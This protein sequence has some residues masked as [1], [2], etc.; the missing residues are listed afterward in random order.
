M[1]RLS[2]VATS[3]VYFTYANPVPSEQDCGQIRAR[4]GPQTIFEVQPEIITVPSTA[5][6][7]AA[8]GEPTTVDSEPIYFL[9]PGSIPSAWDPSANTTSPV[10]G[11][12]TTTASSDA[13]SPTDSDDPGLA[14]NGTDNFPMDASRN[15][16]K[17][18]KVMAYYPDW[19][20]ASFPPEKIDFS[21]FDWIDFAFAVPDSNYGLG[22]DGSDSAPDL[23]K[24]LVS[25]AHAKGKMVKLS[26]GG[27]TGSKCVI[28]DSSSM[29]YN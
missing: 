17:G 25:L 16:L 18:P 2:L 24:R 6:V 27:W 12:A 15:P 5:T 7:T 23:L 20:A 26:I 10:S 19:V 8:S 4:A 22:W 1:L 14:P 11:N 13:P 29:P 28:P 21:R 9:P 3:L